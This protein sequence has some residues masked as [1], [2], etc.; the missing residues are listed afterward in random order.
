MRFDHFSGNEATY[1]FTLCF[2]AAIPISKLF[3]DKSIFEYNIIFLMFSL[4]WYWLCTNSK[5]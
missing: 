1:V 5:T 4:Y 2:L 3:Y